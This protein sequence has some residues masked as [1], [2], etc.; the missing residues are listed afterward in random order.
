MANN[1]EIWGLATHTTSYHILD[2]S[3]Q[4]SKFYGDFRKNERKYAHN[5][6]N[7]PTL[8]AYSTNGYKRMLQ[9]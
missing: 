9:T 5:S 8:V 2:R 3:G 1:Q 6:T 4:D 7:N